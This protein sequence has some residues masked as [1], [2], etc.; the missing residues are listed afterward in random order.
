MYIIPH[1]LDES[2]SSQRIRPVPVLGWSAGGHL[3]T[4][5]PLSTHPLVK[6]LQNLIQWTSDFAT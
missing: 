3:G 1:V 6:I 5:V 2:K 4:R